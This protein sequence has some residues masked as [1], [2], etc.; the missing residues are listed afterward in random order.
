MVGALY[1]TP[2]RVILGSSPGQGTTFCSQARHFTLTV[3]NFIIFPLISTASCPQSFVPKIPTRK[4]TFP[5]FVFCAS[6][7][8]KKKSP[9]VCFSQNFN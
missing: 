7:E 9:A 3:W 5:S 8:E 4:V 1:S 6:T 2:D